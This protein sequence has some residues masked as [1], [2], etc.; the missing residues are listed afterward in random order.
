MSEQQTCGVC[1]LGGL[2]DRSYDPLYSTDLVVQAVPGEYFETG[3]RL[4]KP[5]RFDVLNS[6][7]CL[8]WILTNGGAVVHVL[9]NV[10]RDPD[11]PGQR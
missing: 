6:D 3:I 9:P 1:H 11:V 7:Y 2:G 10:S 8:V 5:S 4:Y